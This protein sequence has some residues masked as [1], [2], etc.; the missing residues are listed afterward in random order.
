MLSEEGPPALVLVTL[1]DASSQA[2]SA[3]VADKIRQAGV[4]CE[5]YAQATKLKKQLRYAERA[6]KRFAVIVGPDEAEKGVV[7]VKDLGARS[8]EEL[9]LEGLGEALRGRLGDKGS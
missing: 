2:L 5:L 8:Q 6:G 7:Q 4:A 1:F 3:R 9:P